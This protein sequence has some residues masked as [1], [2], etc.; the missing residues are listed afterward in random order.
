[1]V[2]V[3]T[4]REASTGEPDGRRLRER[5]EAE[6][7]VA[8]VCF[9]HGP[10]ELLG[11]ELEWTV[12]HA[13]DPRRP[14][15]AAE[16]AAALGP[17]APPAVRPDSPHIALP[18]GSPLSVEPGGQ[19]EISALPQRSLAELFTSVSTDTEY[20][21]TLLGQAGLV[22]GARGFDPYRTPQR[23]LRTPRYAAME[24]AFEPMGPHGLSMMCSTA[25]LQFCVDVGE[26]ASIAARWSALHVVGPAMVAA[27]ANSPGPAG[28]GGN[29]ASSRMWA[30]LGTDPARTRPEESTDDPVGSWARRVLDT[31]LLCVRRQH[32]CWDA[33]PGVTFAD[34]VN[35]AMAEPPTV[36]DL[37]YHLS[38]MFPPVRPHGYF[39]VRYLDAQPGANWLTPVSLLAALTANDRTIDAVLDACSPAGGR[40]LPAA[41]DGLADPV[42]ASTA[43][44]AIEIG[45]G[46]LDGLGLTKEMKAVVDDDLDR[47]LCDVG[48]ADRR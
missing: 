27:F 21:A 14:L 28:T 25:G 33:P 30:V 20:L 6:A 16:L 26:G 44:A 31:P 39:E 1:V 12:H 38:T 24:K 32:D 47:L 46:A 18:A 29:W 9:K 2:W 22:L 36:A 11:V 45:A 4:Q 37:D 34:W 7:Y 10:P 40:W 43:R 8:S 15:D 42:I 5:V 23:V 17:H 41:R 35:G 3:T 48:G 13:D 19:V